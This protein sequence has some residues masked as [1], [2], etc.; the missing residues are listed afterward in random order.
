ML[1]VP[2]RSTD[3]EWEAFVT[4]LQYLRGL[5]CDWL[6]GRHSGADWGRRDR[7]SQISGD[8][9]ILFKKW[10]TSFWARRL[11]GLARLLVGIWHFASKHP[12]CLGKNRLTGS[13]ILIMNSP[14]SQEI[15]KKFGNWAG[16]QQTF[17]EESMAMLLEFLKTAIKRAMYEPAAASN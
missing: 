12:M 15:S 16:P 13:Y 1:Y 2:F 3:Q 7:W 8:H 6:L 11:Q 14:V 9:S 4:V 17:S 10:K 5:L